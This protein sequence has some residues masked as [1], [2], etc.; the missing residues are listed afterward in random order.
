MP[1]SCTIKALIHKYSHKRDREKRRLR[2][3]ERKMRQKERRER[4]GKKNT[5]GSIVNERKREIEKVPERQ[6]E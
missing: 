5:V 6:R 2:E 3:R 1:S 4:G